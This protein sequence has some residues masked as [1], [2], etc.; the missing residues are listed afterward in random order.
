MGYVPLLVAIE[1]YLYVHRSRV[2]FYDINWFSN[3]FPITLHDLTTNITWRSSIYT[4][5][6]FLYSILVLSFNLVYLNSIFIK[7]VSTF[8]CLTSL[9]DF[10]LIF[11]SLFLYQII[12]IKLIFIWSWP[13]FFQ[14]DLSKT[15]CLSLV[16]FF[17]PYLNFLVFISVH[18][19]QIF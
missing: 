14:L 19:N 18:I 9:V 1:N 3:T 2:A 16:D 11:I 8:I 5:N 6:Q 10:P 15:E 13:Y 17:S 4:Y 12:W 7:I